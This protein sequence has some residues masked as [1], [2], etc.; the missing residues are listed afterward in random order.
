M[1]HSMAGGGPCMRLKWQYV[2]LVLAFL[3][4]GAYFGS[5]YN[6]ARN[7]KAAAISGEPG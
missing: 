2:A 3:F 7:L 6:A 1:S 4:A 5:A